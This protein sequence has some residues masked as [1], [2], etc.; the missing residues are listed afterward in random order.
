VDGTSQATTF[1]GN[2]ITIKG[3][4]VAV[5]LKDFVRNDE[6]VRQAPNHT[7]VELSV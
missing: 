5:G 2:E 6:I 4:S 3:D 1:G 7:V